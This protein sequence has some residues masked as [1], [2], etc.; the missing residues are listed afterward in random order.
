MNSDVMSQ[1]PVVCF[2][3]L[4]L[5]DR[6]WG[7]SSMAMHLLSCLA[8]KK[9]QGSAVPKEKTMTPSP[10]NTS[11]NKIPLSPGGHIHRNSV[12]WDAGVLRRLL[13]KLS[14]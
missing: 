11:Q 10:N 12:L 3:L 1:H 14:S 8:C 7:H 4:L 5:S 2:L 6:G 13:G 9:P